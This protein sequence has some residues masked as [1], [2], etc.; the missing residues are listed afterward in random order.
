MAARL[1][2]Q[3]AHHKPGLHSIAAQPAHAVDAASR[4]RDPSFFERWYQPNPFPNYD[5]GATDGQSVGP[6]I[7]PVQVDIVVRRNAI[8]SICVG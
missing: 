5:G 4:P 8:G 7:V 6:L 3:E 1:A 2:T